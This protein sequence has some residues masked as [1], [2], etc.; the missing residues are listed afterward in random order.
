MNN[1]QTVRRT[2]RR[3]LSK[4]KVL[5]LI[6][7]VVRFCFILSICYIIL[8]PLL[9][10]LS[11]SFIE[12]TDIYDPTVKMVPKHFT[13]NNY[14]DTVQYLR[15]FTLLAQTL[16]VCTV[17]T[18]TQVLSCTLAGYGFARFHFKGRGPLFAC[19]IIM[20]LIPN[21]VLITPQYLNFNEVG[22]IGTFIPMLLL[23]LTGTGARC[24]LYI[25]LARQYFRG[26]PKEIDEAAM[27][28]GAGPFKVFT[29]IMLRSAVPTM[30]T[31]GLF[32]FVWQ[33]GENT[34]TGMFL[35]SNWKT[36]SSALSNLGYLMQQDGINIGSTVV[37]MADYD[38]YYT[39]IY[40]TGTI[41]TIVPL[42][43]LYVICQ[44][45]FVESIENSGI[46]G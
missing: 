15:Y 41:L 37:A 38:A 2:L 35:S 40:A 33:W 8:N 24:G 26:I 27:I 4:R 42:I 10:K 22:V 39:A 12:H 30:V 9:T 36:L 18:L 43:L 32:S 46:V 3:N 11:I 14:A 6:L 23:G 16:V 45:F 28:D 7:S 13:L 20:M 21:C 5:S 31:I 1:L 29:S 34:Y 25:F 19:V 17:V 44:K